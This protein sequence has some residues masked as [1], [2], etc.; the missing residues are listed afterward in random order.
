M[1][2]TLPIQD[3]KAS[4]FAR[5]ALDRHWRNA[6]IHALS[7]PRDALLRGAGDMRRSLATR[8]SLLA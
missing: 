8:E 3:L 6:R 1:L 5:A 7:L 4:L 2:E